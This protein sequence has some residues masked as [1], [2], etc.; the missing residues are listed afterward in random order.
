MFVYTLANL[1]SFLDFEYGINM[2]DE[3]IVHLLWADDFILTSDLPY[4]LQ[5]QLDDLFSFYSKFQMN[6]NM[7]T[8]MWPYTAE[9]AT[10]AFCAISKRCA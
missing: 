9:K 6:S 1:K 4:G 2:D 10:N 7:L 8:N 5:K 3:I